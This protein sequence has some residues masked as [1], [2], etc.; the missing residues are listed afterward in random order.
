[1]QMQF[2]ELDETM[3]QIILEC[4]DDFI[5]DGKERITLVEND[6]LRWKSQTITCL[7]LS[8]TIFKQIHSMKGVART[9][10]F[11][12]FHELCE[13][14]STWIREQSDEDWDAPTGNALLSRF[15]L[16]RISFLACEKQ[17]QI[18]HSS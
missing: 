4:Q 7:Q 17:V 1:M 13:E 16:L 15:E 14:I 10:Y 12:D 8:Q 9:I 3:Q 2:E 5:R 6:I 11:G 18:R